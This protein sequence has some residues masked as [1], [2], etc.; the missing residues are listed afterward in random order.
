M[1]QILLARFLLS[2][3][4]IFKI[5]LDHFIIKRQLFT[6]SLYFTVSDFARD[7]I[8]RSR[9]PGWSERELYILS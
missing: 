9:Y 7:E 2:R 6:E 3:F 5:K 4:W 8:A 1:F